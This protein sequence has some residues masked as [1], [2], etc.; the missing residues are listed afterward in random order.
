MDKL[1]FEVVSLILD[2][3]QGPDGKSKLAPYSTISRQWQAA[4]ER[5]TFASLTVE[6]LGQFQAVISS[7]PFRLPALRDL[8]FNVGLPTD[9]ES[10][11]S[12]HRTQSAVLSTITSLLNQLRTWEKKTKDK[13]RFTDDSLGPISLRLQLQPRAGPD[14]ISR[15]MTAVLERQLEFQQKDLDA[16]AK[17]HC[18][19][20][21]KVS[22]D[23]NQYLHPFTSC[24]LA[25]RF[26][27]LQS[28]YLVYMD[29][30]SKQSPLR[31]TIRS[32]L[33]DGINSLGQL[34]HLTKLTILRGNGEPP[35]N[36]SYENLCLE[37]EDQKGITVDLL[38]EAIRKLA[39]KGCLVELGLID[40]LISPD[41][42]R[43]RRQRSAMNHDDARE[44]QEEWPSL[45]RLEILASMVAPS[46]MWYYTG[47][48]DDVEPNI[49][50]FNGW[51][52]HDPLHEWRTSPSSEGFDPLAI[53]L[54][55][56]VRRM[57]RLRS[58]CFRISL[59]ADH[60]DHIIE[61]ECVE[62]GEKFEVAYASQENNE[63]MPVR[64]WRVT[65]TNTNWKVPNEFNAICADWV[66][67]DG[68]VEVWYDGHRL[69]SP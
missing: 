69:E 1:S 28:L 62:A 41:L 29:M 38:C 48:K 64:R 24:Q 32:S 53:D 61:L 4:V 13:T 34:P 31:K 65:N 36:H 5:R 16:L 54:A 30:E 19:S 51:N 43:D 66:G 57:P 22:S 46:G 27:A 26:S 67:P 2:E 23:G 14:R 11:A 47:N 37:V 33:A 68:E 7:S 6:D 42:F 21:L 17:L 52:D 45:Q 9:S 40:E 59:E 56:E 20:R 18:V 63:Y 8:R 58:C 25:T 60:V 12:Y 50:G 35:S 15:S 39:Q 55:A 10:R 44:R 49:Y 3:L